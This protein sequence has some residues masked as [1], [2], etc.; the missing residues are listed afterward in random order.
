MKV[1]TFL[2][3]TLF[4][5]TLVIGGCGYVVFVLGHSGWWFLLAVFM[6]A[7]QF[8]PKSWAKLWVKWVDP[9]A[10]GKS[11]YDILQE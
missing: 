8:S 7:H 4:W 2:L 10:P 11:R 5:Q 6:S 9:N 3:Y 1:F